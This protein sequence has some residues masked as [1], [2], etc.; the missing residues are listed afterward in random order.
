MKSGKRRKANLENFAKPKKN[1]NQ[2]NEDKIL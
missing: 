1:I 2:N